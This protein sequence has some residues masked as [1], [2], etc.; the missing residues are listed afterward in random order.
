MHPHP[1]DHRAA[2]EKPDLPEYLTTAEVS[3]WIRV[4]PATLC[5]WRQSGHGPRVTWMAPACPR[6]L[7]SD[8]QA[9]LDQA[10]AA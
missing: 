10:A 3:A 1:L 7:R 2:V 6:Y 8:V 9:W 4:S 5:R